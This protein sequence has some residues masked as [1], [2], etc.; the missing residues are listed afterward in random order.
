LAASRLGWR[1]TEA[2]G[3]FQATTCLGLKVGYRVSLELASLPA[4]A[5]RRCFHIRN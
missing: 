5:W 3:P 1:R 2:L 4:T